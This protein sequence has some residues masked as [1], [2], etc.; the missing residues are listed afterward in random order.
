MIR[1]LPNDKIVPLIKEQIQRSGIKSTAMPL[2]EAAAKLCNT[3]FGITNAQV[4]ALKSFLD[5][6]R[7]LSAGVHTK[8][9]PDLLLDIWHKS[10]LEVYYQKKNDNAKKSLNGKNAVATKDEKHYMPLEILALSQLAKRHV[11]AWE[12]RE[13]HVTS[14]YKSSTFEA[15]TFPSLFDLSKKVAIKNIQEYD[16]DDIPEHILDDLVLAPRSLGRSVIREFLACAAL[17]SGDDDE[18]TT[19]SNKVSISTVHKA[20]GLEWSD[21]YVPYFNQRFLPTEYREESDDDPIPKRHKSG[22]SAREGDRCNQKCSEWFRKFDDERLGSTADERHL[23]E[24]RRLGYVAATRA[25]EKLV[26]CQLISREVPSRFA[27]GLNTVS[28]ITIEKD[29]SLPC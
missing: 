11:E 19:N 4:D 1:R 25:K 2:Q 10:G 17:Q 8:R 27:E 24:E 26:F 7:A 9:L 14:Y 20:K 28:V 18:E 16:L 3:P 22:C 21:V 29:G 15:Q 12:Q 13:Q 6:I 23:N 5:Q